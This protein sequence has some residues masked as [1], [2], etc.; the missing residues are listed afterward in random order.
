MINEKLAVILKQVSCRSVVRCSHCTTV[1]VI[2]SS[3]DTEQGD[4]NPNVPLSVLNKL[5]SYFKLEIQAQ[6]FFLIICCMLVQ[7]KIKVG[8]IL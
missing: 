7:V 2:F 6:L 4:E 1:S 8:W 3:T 5:P